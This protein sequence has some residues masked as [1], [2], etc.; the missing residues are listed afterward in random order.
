M[1]IEENGKLYDVQD[2]CSNAKDCPHYI[3]SQNHICCIYVGK[4][5][6]QFYCIHLENHPK[7]NLEAVWMPIQG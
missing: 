5:H 1:F 7:I 6:D 2:Q 3:H 4:A